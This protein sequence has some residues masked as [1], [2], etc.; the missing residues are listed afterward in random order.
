MSKTIGK[1]EL[2]RPLGEGQFGKVKAAV[3]TVTGERFAVK[4]I[5]KAAIKSGKDVAT[6]KKEV[7]FMKMLSH[8]N[9]LKLF[10]TLE[11]NEKLY[12][13]LELAA[14]GDLFDKIINTGGF[15]E[16]DACRFFNQLI[17]GL[18]HCHEKGIIHRDL[19]PENLLL[20]LNDVLKI[21]DFGLSS[22]LTTTG[23]L[24]QTHCGSEKY[25][26]PEI[27]QNT[28]PYHGPPIDIW[29]SAVI[30]Y[31]M[32]GGAFPFVEATPKC[33]LYQSLVEG[34]FV[35]PKNFTPELVNLLTRMFAIDPA[36][37]ITIPEIRQHEWF[38]QNDPVH[39][40]MEEP[41]LYRSLAPDVMSCDQIGFE[42]EPVS[43][44]VDVA[45][46]GAAAQK[47]KLGVACKPTDEYATLKSPEEA[48]QQIAA[49]IA[50]CGATSRIKQEH[51]E[52][53][54]ECQGE[55]GP[56]KIQFTVHSE[57]GNTHVTVRRNKGHA[58]DYHKAFQPMR[59]NILEA[60]A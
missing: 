46:E 55:N 29:A 21:S 48:T 9:V 39:M 53:I 33:D 27:M 47:C 10:D 51:G 54:A 18:E 2:G 42:E 7:N 16:Q 26:P 17:D 30:L 56:I 37:R 59:G 22:I 5:R 15:T 8:N 13:V 35:W 20:D 1:Y 60:L 43:R 44:S 19:K 4:I 38:T 52:I 41:V 40:D 24:L 34:K 57:D 28:N 6:V 3:D 36:E 58:L 14:G 31:I 23:Q 45:E 11:D 12:M 49:I 25:A 50:K 32:V